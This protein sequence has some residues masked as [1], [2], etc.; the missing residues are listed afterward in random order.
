MSVVFRAEGLQLKVADGDAFSDIGVEVHAGEAIGITS[1]GTADLCALLEVFA[2]LRAPDAGQVRWKSLPALAKALHDKTA[3]GRQRYRAEQWLRCSNGFISDSVGLL[4]S[5]TIAE[6][7]SLPYSY[8]HNEVGREVADRC[9]KMLVSL[10]LN[11]VASSR[12]GGLPLGIRR[13][14]M[15]ARALMLAPGGLFLDSPLSGVD[16]DS[17][18]IMLE[19]VAKVTRETGMIAIV[20]SFECRRYLPLLSGVLV[21]QGGR[22]AGRIDGREITASDYTQRLERLQLMNDAEA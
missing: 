9:D 2:G 19:V 21:L 7:V 5:L 1:T 4:N 3:P 13:R 8:H 16:E 17:A 18:R 22:I 12:P 6:N 10:D 14:A 20:T 11:R 15:L